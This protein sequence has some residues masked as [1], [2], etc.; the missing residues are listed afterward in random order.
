MKLACEIVPLF[1]RLCW[2]RKNF[3]LHTKNQRTTKTSSTSTTLTRINTKKWSHFY[4]TPTW[5]QSRGWNLTE[6]VIC[7]LFPQRIPSAPF[8]ESLMV[9][10]WDHTK[11]L[12]LSHAWTFQVCFD[13]LFISCFNQKAFFS[14]LFFRTLQCNFCWTWRLTQ[15]DLFQNETPHVIICLYTYSWLY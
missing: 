13:F 15:V 7:S 8:G 4:C 6:R 9:N 1:P 10:C 14:R 2:R 3:F 12:V 11:T 5:T